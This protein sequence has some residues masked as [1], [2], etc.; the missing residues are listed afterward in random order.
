MIC[1]AFAGGNP[2]CDPEAQFFGAPWEIQPRMRAICAA[3][4]SPPIFGITEPE[5]IPTPVSLLSR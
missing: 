1:R 4:N 5:H 2:R 3:V